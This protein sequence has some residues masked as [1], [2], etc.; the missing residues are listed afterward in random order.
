[1]LLG[2]HVRLG[3]YSKGDGKSVPGLYLATCNSTPQ[4]QCRSLDNL[5]K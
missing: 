4:N 1:M 3:I 2:D 5:T